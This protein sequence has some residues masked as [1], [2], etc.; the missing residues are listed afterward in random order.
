MEPLLITDSSRYRGPLTDLALDLTQKSAGFRRSLPPALLASL[1]DLVRA[2]ELLLLQPHRRPRHPSRGHRA[3]VEERL[4]PGS[5]EARF[6][7]RSQGPHRRA[8]MDRQRRPEGRHCHPSR[9]LRKFTGAS[10]TAARGSPLGRRSVTKERIRLAPG[11]S[12][13][14]MSRW[15]P[16]SPSVRGAL[17]RFLERFE[18]VY[19][20]LGKPTGS[21]PQPARTTACYGCI[22][23]WRATAAWR[24]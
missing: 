20:N 2:M 1:A 5:P 24:A 19:G 7:A 4:Q 13:G 11:E 21:S 10:A 18:R 22:P 3:R 23:L 12:A 6:A 17:P 8:A 14:A 16:T 9:R 15:G